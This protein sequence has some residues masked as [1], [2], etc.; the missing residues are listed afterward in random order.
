MQSTPTNPETR[1]TGLTVHKPQFAYWLHCKVS[2]SVRILRYFKLTGNLK[3]Q[4][5]YINLCHKNR[6]VI[7][8]D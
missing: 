5:T 6:L 3:M 2:V 1:G 4:K 8:I 7:K